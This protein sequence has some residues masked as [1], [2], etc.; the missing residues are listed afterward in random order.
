MSNETP[1]TSSTGESKQG[2]FAAIVYD[3]GCSPEHHYYSGEESTIKAF[4]KLEHRGYRFDV[5]PVAFRPVTSEMVAAL[6]VKVN[7]EEHQRELERLQNELER[8]QREHDNL[9]KEQDRVRVAMKT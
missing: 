1:A 8:V 4:A 5:V 9:K 2:Q 3:Y 7:Q 6:K